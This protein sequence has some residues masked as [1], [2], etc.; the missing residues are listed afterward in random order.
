MLSLPISALVRNK[1]EQFSFGLLVTGFAGLASAEEFEVSTEIL[2]LDGDP[3]YGEY[4]GGECLTCHRA[5]GDFDGIPAI[6]GWDTESFVTALHAYKAKHRENA[7]MQLIAGRLSDEEIAALAS[8][9]E[10]LE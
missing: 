1:L 2:A 3:E 7:A 8:Y 5:D 4:L 9:F 10:T 6:T